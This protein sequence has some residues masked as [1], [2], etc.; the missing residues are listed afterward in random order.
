MEVQLDT[1]INKIKEDG[2]K[3]ADERANALLR[4][5]EKKAQSIVDAAK[6]E[7]ERIIQNAESQ[8]K[9]TEKRGIEAIQ[10]AERD[11]ILS[12]KEKIVNLFDNSLQKT[13]SNTLKG[14]ALKEVILQAFTSWDFGKNVNVFLSLSPDDAAKLSE[15]LRRQIQETIKENS[16]EIKVDPTIQSG[17]RLTVGTDS[18][19]TYDFSQKTIQESLSAFLTPSL[20]ELLKS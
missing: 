18:S 15:S 5:S 19:L 8:A 14:D 20:K 13:L 11:L 9:L 1:L 17:F 2:I 6:R 12:L 16:V 10:Q 3:Q 4:E 7:S